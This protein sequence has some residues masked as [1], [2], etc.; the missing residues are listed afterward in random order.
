[1]FTQLLYMTTLSDVS[2]IGEACWVE[3]WISSA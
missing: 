3:L 1:M 2:Y